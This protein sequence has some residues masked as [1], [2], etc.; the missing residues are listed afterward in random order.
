[1]LYFISKLQM[2]DKLTIIKLALEGL[3]GSL[4]G[5]IIGVLL[6]WM[7]LPSISH[8]IP[9]VAADVIIFG[10]AIIYTLI[11]IFQHK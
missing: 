5:L 1:M 10:G 11:N 9:L 4:F 3:F 8:P 6:G 7:F 2:M